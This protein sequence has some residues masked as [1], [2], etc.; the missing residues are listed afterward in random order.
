MKGY[1]KVI[2][3]KSKIIETKNF[4]LTL[5]TLFSKTPKIKNKQLRNIYLLSNLLS[6]IYI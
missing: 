1:R 3:K 5:I 6:K 2:N 4:T